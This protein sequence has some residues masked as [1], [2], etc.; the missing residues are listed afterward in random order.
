MDIDGEEAAWDIVRER[1][2]FDIE[3]G[4]FIAIDKV[5]P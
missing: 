5:F 1:I 2:N 4:E 3:S